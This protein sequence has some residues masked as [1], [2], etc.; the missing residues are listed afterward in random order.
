M[1]AIDGSETSLKALDY[2]V[3]ISQKFDSQITLIT[4]IE[5]FK[6][7]FAAEYG[8]W[9]TEARIARKKEIMDG[10]NSAIN[11]IREKYGEINIPIRVEE[12]RPAQVIAEIAKNENFD[13]VIVGNRGNNR[14]K[15]WVLGSVSRE[16]VNESQVPVLIVK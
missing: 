1:V 10:L 14:I 6:L 16:I 3:V 8:L 12:G 11:N 2:G 4:I 7:P 5:E 9:S 15:G 13:L